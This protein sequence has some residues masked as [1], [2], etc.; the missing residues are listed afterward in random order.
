MCSLKISA[1]NL[2]IFFKMFDHVVK[3][4]NKKKYKSDTQEER[5]HLQEIT[6]DIDFPK[7]FSFL[8]E[9]MRGLLIYAK[10]GEFD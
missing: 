2:Q 10:E 9:T 8:Y 6:A 5:M 1:C 7:I 3:K 4:Y